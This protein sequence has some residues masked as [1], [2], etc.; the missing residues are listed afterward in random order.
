MKRKLLI[1]AAIFTLAFGSGQKAH[2]QWVQVNGLYGG[3]ISALAVSD[4]NLFAGTE[5]EGIFRST[6]YGASWNSV[7]TGFP[8]I[9]GVDAFAV[10]DT[11]LYAGTTDNGV[12]LSTNNGASWISLGFID[13]SSLAVSG[14]NLIIGTNNGV[15]ILTDNGNKWVSDGLINTQV[16]ALA[17]IGTKF[18]AGTATGVFESTDSGATWVAVDAGLIQ[19]G[20]TLGVH[21]L[22]ASGM[23]LFAAAGGGVYRS[24]N[25]GASWNVVDTEIPANINI[26]SFAVLD[27]NLF[28]GSNNLYVGSGEGGVFRSPD[29]GKSW[30]VAD[31]GLPTYSNFT[32]FAI[33]G[34]NLFVGTQS[35]GLFLSTDNGS[36]S[37]INKY[38][39]SKQ[40]QCSSFGCYGF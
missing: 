7:T 9:I 26:N 32:S 27:S 8:S 40:E 6:D 19:H 15:A 38:Q 22:T 29:N 28:V 24:T 17:V 21:A 35:D 36:S 10:S 5:N 12:F 13:V 34:T 25:N 37:E 18:F 3:F 31:T 2:A 11:D 20:D 30:L 39:F 16:N 1:F 14:E 4:S 33:S 23:N